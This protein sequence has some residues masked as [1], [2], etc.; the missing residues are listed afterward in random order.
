MPYL[1]EKQ[2]QNAAERN[3][4]LKSCFYIKFNKQTRVT[5]SR[6]PEEYIVFIIFIIMWKMLHGQLFYSTGTEV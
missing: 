1:E 6:D 3:F 2:G 4:W 5:L